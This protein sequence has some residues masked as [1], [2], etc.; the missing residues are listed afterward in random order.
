MS[1]LWLL[2]VAAISG[3]AGVVLLPLVVTRLVTSTRV[4]KVHVLTE[5]VPTY[6]VVASAGLF[7]PTWRDVRVLLA[8]LAPRLVLWSLRE[9]LVTVVM[10]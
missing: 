2:T 1:Q 9:T 3:V 6:S 10:R 4:P 7:V 8:I 5:V